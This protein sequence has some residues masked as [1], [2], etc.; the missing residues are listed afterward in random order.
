MFLKAIK[1]TALS[2]AVAATLVQPALA[3]STVLTFDGSTAGNAAN[4]DP[5][6]SAAGV[7]FDNAV[8]DYAYDANGNV[9]GPQQWRVDHSVSTPVTVENALTQGY[10]GYLAGATNNALDARWSPILMHFSGSIDLGSF[11]FQEPNSTYG[12]PPPSEIDFLNASGQIIGNLMY[13]QGVPNAI[14]GITA[15][16]F[17]V[18]DVLLASGTFYKDITYAAVPLPA[19]LPL[20]LSG[21][22]L[23]GLIARRRRKVA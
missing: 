18:T 17:G 7:T 8:F 12:N 3:A 9:I 10:G 20:A 4:L 15:P 16:I 6:A 21:L 23:S 22:G 5:G 2:V 13:T 14:V 1:L 19:A 11:S